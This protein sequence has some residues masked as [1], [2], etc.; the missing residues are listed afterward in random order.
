M[1]MVKTQIAL[2]T[3][4]YLTQDQLNEEN[5]TWGYYTKSAFRNFLDECEIPQVTRDH[6][7]SG[8]YHNLADLPDDV[9][10]TLLSLAPENGDEGENE[11]EPEQAP[12]Q[13]AETNTETTSDT[14]EDEE[15]TTEDT[16]TASA[17]TATED[18][19]KRRGRNRNQ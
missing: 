11:Q 18:A 15:E 14:T 16:E 7:N 8:V 10:N 9:S 12:E 2:A 13:N 3:A 1:T 17:E 19:S 4:G 5:G 6:L